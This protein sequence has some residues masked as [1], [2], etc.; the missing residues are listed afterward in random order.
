MPIGSLAGFIAIAGLSVLASSWVWA[1]RTRGFTFCVSY[2]DLFTSFECLNQPRSSS[3]P[4]AT[5][6][7]FDVVL[8]PSLAKYFWAY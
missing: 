7:G 5:E 6:L 3:V 4:V 8:G 2:V 1:A